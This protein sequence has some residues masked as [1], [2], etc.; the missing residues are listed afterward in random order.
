LTSPDAQ[1]GEL[2]ERIITCRA[3]PRLVEWRERV[4]AVRTARFAHE[5]YWGR[6]VPGFGDPRARLLIVG[7]AP[8]AHGG[9]RTGRVFTGDRSG[10]FLFAALHRAG[11]AS[12]PTSVSADDGLRLE[13][14]WLTAVNRCAPPANKPTPVERDTCRPY[15]EAELSILTA[16]RV[17]VCLGGW[18]W[19]GTLRALASLG[20]TSD[21]KPRFGHAAEADVGGWH[22][23]GC[24]HP[25][26]QNTFTGRLTPAMLDRVLERA[27]TRAGGPPNR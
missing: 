25:S 9:N 1:L 21:P 24:Y 11:F 3:C 22:L 5:R 19:D 23:V 12:Q 10:D 8:A 18:A 17:I 27:R 20:A 6:P 2:R 16:A 7:L 15:L 13:G 4:A 26:Q 14:V